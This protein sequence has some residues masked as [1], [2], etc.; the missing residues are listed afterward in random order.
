MLRDRGYP[1]ADIFVSPIKTWGCV[2]GLAVLSLGQV[3]ILFLQIPIVFLALIPYLV[4][5]YLLNAARNN[6]FAICHEKLLVVNSNFP[7]R[8]FTEI[9]FSEIELIT[10]ANSRSWIKSVFLAISGNY[11]KVETGS[12]TYHFPCEGLAEDTWDGNWT[13]RT[14]DDLQIALE[15]KGIPVS[16]RMNERL[17]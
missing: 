14:L 1:S 15:R 16:N 7:F 10:F 17:D 11:L 4:V 12:R 9:P 5:S 3:L 13:K 6:S 2:V 8:R